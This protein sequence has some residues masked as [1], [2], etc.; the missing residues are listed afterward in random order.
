MCPF[1]NPI[2]QFNPNELVWQ[3]VQKRKHS[4]PDDCF[5]GP[6]RVVCKDGDFTYRITSAKRA[7]VKNAGR[8]SINEIKKFTIP[9]TS[10]WKLNEKNLGRSKTSCWM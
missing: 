9:D 6:H 8:V 7:N 3:H 5:T 4:K 1:T 2:R 10:E